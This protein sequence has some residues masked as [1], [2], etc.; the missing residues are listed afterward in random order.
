MNTKVKG[1][2][3][4]YNSRLSAIADRLLA[5]VKKNTEEVVLESV[6]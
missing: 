4:I 6:S 5:R 3:E 2:G 1:Q